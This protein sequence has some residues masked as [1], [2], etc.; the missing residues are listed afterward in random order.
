M[1]T[2]IPVKPFADDSY[3][4]RNVGPSNI[5]MDCHSGTNNGLSITGKVGSADFAALN[6]VAPHYLAAGGTLHGKGGYNFPDQTYAFY[7]SNSHRAIGIGNSNGT[8][9]A[10]PCVGCHMSASEKHLFKAVSSATN[11]II[12]KITAPVCVSCH[13]DSLGVT[14]LTTKQAG[15]A[16]TLDALKAMLADKGFIY[17]PTYPYFFNTNWGSGQSGANTMGAA[18]NYVLLLKEPGA[19][20]HNLA[21]AKQ[22]ASNSID[23]LFNGNITGNIDTAL[24]YLVSQGKITQEAADSVAS[25]ITESSCTSCHNNTSKSNPAHLSYKFWL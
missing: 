23:Y 25:F 10:G 1:R 21:Y 3:V 15:F 14:Q 4:N 19:Y 22:L 12:G 6:F 7:S 24:A 11:G 17:T 18:F 2:V 16:N 8:G 13:A 5:C 20:A 9:T